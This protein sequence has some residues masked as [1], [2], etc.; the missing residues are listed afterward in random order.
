[1]KNDDNNN[2]ED[3]RVDIAEIE[4]AM[5]NY[6][7]LEALKEVLNATKVLEGIDV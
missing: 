1:M 4:F 2:K 6:K 7:E 3:T 5:H